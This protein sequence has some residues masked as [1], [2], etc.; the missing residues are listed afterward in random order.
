MQTF[1]CV[2]LGS[3]FLAIIITP[4]VIKLGRRIKA[5]DRPGIRTVHTRAVPRIG[6]V[7]IFLSAMILIVMVLFLNNSIGEKMTKSGY[8][9]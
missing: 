1:L 8:E 7:T 4:I 6:G 9:R 3:A 5:V 2:Y